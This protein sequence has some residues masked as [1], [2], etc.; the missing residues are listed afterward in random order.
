MFQKSEGDFRIREII[1]KFCKFPPQGQRGAMDKEKL[2][3]VFGNS[4]VGLRF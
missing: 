1:W 4:F 2:H 3:G